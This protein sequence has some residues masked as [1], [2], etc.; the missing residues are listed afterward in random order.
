MTNPTKLFPLFVVEDLAACKRFYVEGLGWTLTHDR[1]VYLQVRSSAAED[2]PELCFMTREATPG[3]LPPFA[4]AGVIVSVPVDDADA[5]HAQL[6]ARGLKPLA[7]PSDKPWSWRSYMI[8]DPAGVML[9]FFHAIPATAAK[10][11]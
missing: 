2:A 3:P 8:R 1:P 5:H 7:E 6:R 10:T 11:G 4:G 9:D